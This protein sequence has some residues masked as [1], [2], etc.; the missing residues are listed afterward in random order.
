MNT[1]TN[2]QIEIINE[3]CGSE[4][5]FLL[6]YT[7]ISALQEEP[8]E[9]EY[10]FEEYNSDGKITGII[11]DVKL[12]NDILNVEIII[13]GYYRNLKIDEIFTS[14]FLSVQYDMLQ[15][16]SC[17]YSKEQIEDFEFMKYKPYS[18]TV[19]ANIITEI[20]ALPLD[21]FI[22]YNDVAEYLF[23]MA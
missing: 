5:N 11:T 13:E 23:Q 10:R 7:N 22:E 15:D 3:A 1:I 9:R 14:G 20:K 21:F 17:K 6:H 2:K 8:N 4:K 18:L 19:E 16:D 12:E